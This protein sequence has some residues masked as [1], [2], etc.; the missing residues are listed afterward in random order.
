MLNGHI[1]VRD[2][3]CLH[4]LRGIDHQQRTFASSNRTAHLV[5]KVDVSRSVDQV[6]HIVLAVQLIGHLNGVALD[7][8]ATLF[9]QLHVV[10]HLSLGDLNGVG[11][12]EQTVGQCRLAVIDMGN[13]TE[14][15]YIVHVVIAYFKMQ[16]YEK[17]MRF[18]S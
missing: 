15:P 18:L 17:Y 5:G 13:D 14:I 8:D 3:L 11:M 2:G 16:N 4:A 12:F 1:E 10:E 9:L 6:Q 7:G